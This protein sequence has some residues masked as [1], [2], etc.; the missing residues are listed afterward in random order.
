MCTLRLKLWIVPI[1]HRNVMT[2]NRK[3]KKICP[4]S[5]RQTSLTKPLTW[6]GMSDYFLQKDHAT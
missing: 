6:S 2:I 5:D 3:G 4:L 1:W